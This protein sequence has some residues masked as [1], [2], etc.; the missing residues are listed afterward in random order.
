LT[1]LRVLEGKLGDRLGGG[2]SARLLA[3]NQVSVIITDT[4]IDELRTNL[5]AVNALLSAAADTA[6]HVE[7]QNAE[8]RQ[9]VKLSIEQIDRTL[10]ID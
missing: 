2:S 8:M 4:N 6:S 1:E 10:D 7:G 9:E 5:A 3:V